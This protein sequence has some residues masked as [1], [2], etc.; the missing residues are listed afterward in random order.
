MEH[1][2]DIAK[3]KKE[4]TTESVSAQKLNSFF[5]GAASALTDEQIDELEKLNES[6]YK[7]V[8]FIV[9]S[10]RERKEKINEI[11]AD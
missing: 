10:A 6:N 3:L 5:D 9:D 4:I 8:K 2:L 11:T 1:L 7:L